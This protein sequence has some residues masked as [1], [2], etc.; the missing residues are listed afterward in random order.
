MLFPR[1]SNPSPKTADI[2]SVKTKISTLF[3]FVIPFKPLPLLLS[4]V[5]NLHHF[6]CR[7]ASTD[8]KRVTSPVWL[9][10]RVLVGF[11]FT[12]SL[13]KLQRVDWRLVS[14]TLA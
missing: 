10:T 8:E 9:I 2:A 1:N 7:R 5:M 6:F 13:L 3:L 12:Y 11:S 4:T 14:F